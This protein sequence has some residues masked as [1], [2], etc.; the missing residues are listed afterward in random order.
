MQGA[1]PDVIADYLEDM[2]EGT[3]RLS[4]KLTLQPRGISSQTHLITEPEDHPV[5]YLRNQSG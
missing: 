3:L 2:M 1:A 5:G 4:T